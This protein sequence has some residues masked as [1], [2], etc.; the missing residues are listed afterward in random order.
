MLNFSSFLT[1]EKAKAE[2]FGSLKPD[3]KG[4][5]HETLVGYH[6]FGGKHMSKH[7]DVE[8]KSPKE[9]HDEIAAKLGG[10]K[11]E[12]YKNFSERSRKAA[13]DIKAQLGLKDGDIQNVQW[14]SKAGDIER[15]T[16]IPSTQRE[17]DSDLIVTDKTGKHHGVSLK[18]S[19]DNKPITI[20]NNG[21]EAMYGGHVHVKEHQKGILSDYPE[22]SNLKGNAK[23]EAKARE[24]EKNA[25]KKTV[26]ADQMRKAWME[27][28]PKA[29]DDI[30][31]RNKSVLKKVAEHIT[32]HLT[33]MSSQQL[34][35]HIRHLVIHGYSTPKEAQ[36]HTHLRHFTG[37][38]FEPD[39]KSK[40]PSTDYE[41]F[42]NDPEKLSVENS[43]T[44]LYFNYH[45]D[46][47]PSERTKAVAKAAAAAF[48]DTAAKHVAGNNDPKSNS[49]KKVRF[50]MQTVKFSNQADP[51][52]PVVVVGRDVENKKDEV[53][54]QRIKEQ[55]YARKAAFEKK[56][57]ERKGVAAAPVSSEPPNKAVDISQDNGEGVAP[58]APNIPV[59][60]KHIQTNHPMLRRMLSDFRPTK[61]ALAR[62]VPQNDSPFANM[63]N[64]G[65]KKAPNG[66][67][68]TDHRAHVDTTSHMGFQERPQS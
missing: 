67:P 31:T 20:S 17:D 42:L 2:D 49:G 48:A 59:T 33:G 36:G 1:E 13:E 57:A 19:D 22:I 60:S 66:W 47:A 63:S 51:I 68:V 30:K 32:Q 40:R 3:P 27:L 62:K 25:N 43:G 37:G 28:N 21:E 15:A 29:S 8:G 38:G 18:V 7:P 45:L 64:P 35:D 50:A 11:S 10:V 56:M 55:Y 23:V 39:M 65:I 4:K 34:A 52:S 5:L 6:L 44:S 61:D 26:P 24:K 53:D 41:H 54:H 46:D 14:T 12:K 16:G 9:V 58:V